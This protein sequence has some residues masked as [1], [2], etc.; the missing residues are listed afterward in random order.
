MLPLTLPA[1]TASTDDT[2][3]T[4]VDLAPDAVALTGTGQGPARPPVPPAAPAPAAPAAHDPEPP[5]AAVPSAAVPSAAV[6]IPVTVPS[7]VAVPTASVPA[8]STPV[9]LVDD[10]NG[11]QP[12]ADAAA[13]TTASPPLRAAAAASRLDAGVIGFG[14]LFLAL[15]GTGVGLARRRA[16]RPSRRAGAQS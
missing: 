8:D 2:W 11:A 5:T 1:P 7:S 14:V 4:T 13:P 3:A 12:S 10:G 9:P 6:P 15:V 16:R